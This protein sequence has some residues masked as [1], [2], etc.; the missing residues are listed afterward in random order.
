MLTYVIYINE[1]KI[2]ELQ[3]SVF[4]H[5]TKINISHQKTSLNLI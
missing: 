5:F 1:I 3:I 4:Q 2:I